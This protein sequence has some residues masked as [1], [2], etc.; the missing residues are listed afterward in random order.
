MGQKPENNLRRG[1]ENIKQT[2]FFILFSKAVTFAQIVSENFFKSPSRNAWQ[3][4]LSPANQ[5][6]FGMYLTENAFIKLLLAFFKNLIQS[7][8]KRIQ[9]KIYF[10]VFN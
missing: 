5:I 8:Y 4:I 9:K 7:T 2:L 6:Y 1:R 3:F 10:T